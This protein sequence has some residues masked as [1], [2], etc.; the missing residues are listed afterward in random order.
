MHSRALTFDALARR[1]L[2]GLHDW[3]LRPHVS[4][5]WGAPDSIAELERMYFG[6][7]AASRR[8]QAFVARHEGV[9]LGFIQ[10]YEVFGCTD[11]WWPDETDPGARGID[12]FLV[13]ARSLGKGLGRL[14]I[15]AF[16]ANLFGDARVSSVQADPHPDNVRAIRC[17]QS[18]GFDAVGHV[19]TPDG[20]ALLMRC[21]RDS[22]TS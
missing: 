20:D 10:L 8:V 1:E 12:Q 2:A 5:W 16:V 4:Q 14:M 6:G 3:L 9:P 13:D 17:Y 11:G 18:L 7:D 15:G 19:R 21:T 22:L